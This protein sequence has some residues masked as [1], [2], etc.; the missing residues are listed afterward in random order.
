MH[1]WIPGK[2]HPSQPPSQPTPLV[3]TDLELFKETLGK[4]SK[5]LALELSRSW[6]KDH[7]L[8]FLKPTLNECIVRNYALTVISS[9]GYFKVK[10]IFV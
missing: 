8:K 9:D 10:L 2:R 7:H 5:A 4:S 6:V 1:W 3:G